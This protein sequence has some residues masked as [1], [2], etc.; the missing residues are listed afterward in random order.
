MLLP[1]PALTPRV[2]ACSPIMASLCLPSWVRELVCLLRNRTLVLL[3][4]GHRQY[5]SCGLLPH[6]PLPLNVRSRITLIESV[7]VRLKRSWPT[8]S[9]SIHKSMYTSLTSVYWISANFKS[10]DRDVRQN[11]YSLTLGS[12]G[13][14]VAVLIS[15]PKPQMNRMEAADSGFSEENTCSSLLS[16]FWN[17]G[18]IRERSCPRGRNSG[19]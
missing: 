2:L 9:I 8:E 4:F 1:Q 12:L 14:T 11:V 18:Q 16:E 3:S 10:S 17:R 5:P 15:A 7:L 13:S 19:H 6:H